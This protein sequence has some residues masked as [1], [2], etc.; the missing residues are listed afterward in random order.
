MCSSVSTTYIGYIDMSSWD[1]SNPNYENIEL[2][3]TPSNIGN[4]IPIRSDPIQYWLLKCT[5]T[6]KYQYT[7]AQIFLEKAIRAISNKCFVQCSGI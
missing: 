5:C 7:T 4:I 2:L 3:E 6:W 1:T